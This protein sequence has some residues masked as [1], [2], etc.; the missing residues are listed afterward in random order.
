M[1]V[2][3][4]ETDKIL[5]VLLLVRQSLSDTVVD[6]DA[7]FNIF[8]MSDNA[9]RRELYFDDLESELCSSFNWHILLS[10]SCIGIIPLLFGNIGLAPWL[11]NS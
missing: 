7:L 2:V 5:K 9:L 6:N 8:L 11:S 10:T 3:A 1:K 4:E